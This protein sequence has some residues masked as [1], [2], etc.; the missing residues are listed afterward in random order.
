MSDFAARLLAWFDLHGRHDL[1]W[2][3]PRTPYRVWVAEVMLQQ[4]R[5]RTAIG[6]FDAFLTRFPEPA[7]LAAAPLDAVLAVWSGLGYYARA[8][9]LHRAAQIVVRD[10][11]G[12]LPERIESLARLPGVGRSTAGAILAQAHGQRHPILDG[13]ARRVLARHAAVAGDPAAPAVQRRLWELSAERLPQARLADYTQ[14]LMDLGAGVC[15]RA[16]PSCAGCPLRDDC[17]ALAQE[18]VHELPTPRTPRSRPLRRTAMLLARDATG[19]VLLQRRPP[20]G[21][22]PDLWSLPEGADIAALAGA[23][24]VVLDR[25]ARTRIRH[26]FT[27]F[28]LEIDVHRACAVAGVEP[29]GD[30]DSRWFTPDAARALGLP[31]PVRRLL[32]EVHGHGAQAD[33][34]QIDGH[35]GQ[36]HR[37]PCAAQNH[38]V[39]RFAQPETGT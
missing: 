22:W 10:H 28:T 18:R 3:H 2:Q 15:I 30:A 35:G 19:R 21:V 11:G 8:R 20:T 16:R 5:V 38:M 12:E 6:Y 32:D 23:V 14:A 29:V 31:Q 39:R 9:N 1:P 34:P 25:C 13:N 17:L 7:V 27:H 36:G 33:R 37:L 26:Q 24:P 4:T